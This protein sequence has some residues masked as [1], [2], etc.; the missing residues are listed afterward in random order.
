MTFGWITD[1]YRNTKEA[2]TAKYFIA[3]AK[4]KKNEVE[5][6]F[7]KLDPKE[8]KDKERLQELKEEMVVAIIGK[9]DNKESGLL[10][11]F[12]ITDEQG[13]EITKEKLMEEDIIEVMTLFDDL[14]NELEKN[15]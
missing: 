13:K 3:K 2:I 9:K 11:I 15:V 10:Y 7:S 6:E 8:K 5:N 12:D 14:L 1:K 4:K